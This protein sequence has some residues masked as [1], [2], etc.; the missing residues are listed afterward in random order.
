[1]IQ[2]TGCGKEHTPQVQVDFEVADS[3]K[4]DDAGEQGR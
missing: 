3:K 4:T 2:A 1:M